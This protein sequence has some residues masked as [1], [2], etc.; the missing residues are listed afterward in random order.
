MGVRR[1]AFAL[2]WALACQPTRF[3]G[4]I[5][6]T[7]GTSLLAKN[8]QAS[9]VSRQH[10]LSLASIASK[11]APTGPY[12][13]LGYAKK[14]AVME[15]LQEL[16][17]QS[18][19][20]HGCIRFTVGAS[21]LAKNLQ[22]SGVSRQHALSLASIASKLAPTGP[23]RSLGYAKKP[24][25]MERLQ[26]LACQPI[27]FHGRIRFTVGASLLAKNVQA[28]GVSRQHGLSLTS[29]ASKLAPTGPYRSLGYAKKPA[30]MERLQEL[31]CQSTRFHGRIRFTVGASLLAKNVQASGVSRQHGL[32]L[33]SIA[34]KLAPTGPYRSLGYA[35]KTAVMERLQE[36]AC[37]PIRFHGRIRF[38]VG[39][40]LLAKNVQAPGVS[41]QH[42]LSLTSIAS[43]LAPTGPCRSLGYAKKPAVMER[44]QELA[45]Q[46]TRFHGRIRFTV[47]ASL[48][49]KN[50]QASG[51]SRQHGLS[52]TSIA[53]KLA[54]TGPY[55][56][57]GYA[58]KPA[59]MERLQELACQSIRFHGCIRFTVGASLLAKNV[60]ASGVSRQHALSLTSIAS[61]LAPTGPYRSFGY[62]K[63]TAVME[64]LQELACQSI[65]FHGCIRFTVGASLLSKNVQ[66]SG[67][68]RQHALSLT[69]IASKLA[70]TGPYR[71]LGY[72]KKP[73]VMERL[74]ELAC[75]PI[76][77]HGRIRFT[78][79]A[80]LLAKNVQASGVSRQH[81]LSLAS[82]ASKLA[83]T[84][85][86]RSL[87]YAKKPAV[88]ERLQELACQSTRF[89]GC[90][91][92]TV[93]ASLLAKNVQAP[94]VSRQ[95]AL[96]LASIASRLAP[97]GPYRSFGYAKKNRSYG[98]AARAGLPADQISRT[99][100]FHC[101]SELAREERPGTGGI[102]AARVIVGVHRE[103][104][105]SYRAVLQLWICKKNPAISGAIK[106]AAVML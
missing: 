87:G 26:E 74:Q 92:F 43:K 13:S 83:P 35:K 55:R 42:A 82:I 102:Q 94:G 68:S 34:S 91:R 6:F 96:S 14:P 22:A 101:R 41:R 86:Y 81:A 27:S 18:I 44:L 69:S 21:L 11:L 36:L 77:F 84:G 38:T 7:V 37:Q 28:S 103:Q 76:R 89:H 61:K 88:M 71:S 58:K 17:C 72:A 95:H 75:Q 62:A 1:S 80:S 54:P 98:T 4:C 100:S 32:S 53:S 99:Y 5:R 23:Y 30:V 10:A 48:L 64:R 97:T 39:A 90:I 40:S 9:G 3:H 16:A 52:L 2:L 60:Q 78:V 49:A 65:R 56:S 8:L 24:A 66:A 45:C 57:F 19:R 47:G 105:R 29:I 70:P 25:V 15:R 50:V 46:S 59:V 33:T 63:K 31:A 104:A 51:V 12:R 67:V 79:G 85:P 106:G 73:A 20:F 93:G